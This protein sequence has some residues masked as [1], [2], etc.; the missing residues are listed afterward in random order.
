MDELTRQCVGK[1]TT[2]GVAKLVGLALRPV[3]AIAWEFHDA[4]LVAPIL[5]FGSKIQEKSHVYSCDQTCINRSD[6][7]QSDTSTVNTTFVRTVT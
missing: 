7:D 6:N 5:K 4:D 2:A 1:V 3:A